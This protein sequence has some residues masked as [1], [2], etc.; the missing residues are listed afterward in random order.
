MQKLFFEDNIN[1]VM[2]L[3]SELK[4]VSNLIL[5]RIGN[6]KMFYCNYLLYLLLTNCWVDDTKT[7][8]GQ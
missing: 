1:I 3:K 6:R 8:S 5:I 4:E 2:L 7:S